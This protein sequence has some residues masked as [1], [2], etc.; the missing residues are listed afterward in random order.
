MRKKVLA[1]LLTVSMVASIL[2]GCGAKDTQTESKQES[3]ATTSKTEVKEDKKEETKPVEKPVLTWY[4]LDNAPADLDRVEEKVNEMLE[5]K[6]DATVDFICP[7]N[8][9]EKINMMTTAGEEFDLMFCARWTNPNYVTLAKKGALVDLTDLV[10]QYGSA[11]TEVVPE[12]VLDGML[13]D[14]GLYGIPNYQTSV[15]ENQ[16][17]M[18]KELADKY[19]FDLDGLKGSV[20][21]GTFKEKME[22]ILETIKQ[23]EPDLIPL[24]HQNLGSV[25]HSCYEVL[26]QTSSTSALEIA[27]GEIV[28]LTECMKA[29][30]EVFCDWYDK[31][32]IREDIAT[33]TDHSGDV[34]AGR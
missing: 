16:I 26:Q 19:E 29:Y 27:T 25:L 17:V 30:A 31:G 21:D 28:P 6:L 14:G 12:A 9:S 11:I 32:Y 18:S 15:R 1:A 23:N 20:A 13:V 24:N 22:V 33:V 34:K 2:S 3:S 5:G 8:L 10:A 7:G 4:I